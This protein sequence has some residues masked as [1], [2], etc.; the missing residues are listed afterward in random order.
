MRWFERGG[1]DEVGCSIGNLGGNGKMGIY[2]DE[3]TNWN[4]WMGPWDWI[5]MYVRT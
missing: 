5:I 3:I 1:Y 4:R 2:E